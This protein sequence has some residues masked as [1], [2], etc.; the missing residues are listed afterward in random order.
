M[1]PTDFLSFWSYKVHIFGQGS[2]LQ[3]IAAAHMHVHILM[4][5]VVLK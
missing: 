1:C 5:L 4:C 3:N 2:A